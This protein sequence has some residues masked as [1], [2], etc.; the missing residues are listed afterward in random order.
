MKNKESVNKNQTEKK[1]LPPDASAIRFDRDKNETYFP[2]D[3]SV[4][5]PD[6]ESEP[7]IHLSV[8]P[9]ARKDSEARRGSGEEARRGSTEKPVP[10]D[11]P[12]AG[13]PEKKAGDPPKENPEGKPDDKPVELPEHE[14]DVPEKDQTFTPKDQI[15]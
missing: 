2:K 5:P 1:K 13:A 6:H 3:E 10:P 14:L 4:E 12:S 11:H 7:T 8:E 9:E 15:H